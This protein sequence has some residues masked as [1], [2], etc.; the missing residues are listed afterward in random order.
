MP[1]LKPSERNSWS[2]KPSHMQSV[3]L[4]CAIVVPNGLSVFARSAS[5]WIHWWS[6]ETS[7]NLSMSSWVTSRHS[8]GPMVCPTS[9]LSSSIPFTVVGVL[10][11]RSISTA[12]VPG[13]GGQRVSQRALP[14]I[15]ERP[16]V[17]HQRAVEGQLQQRLERR[18]EALS[19]EALRLGVDLVARPHPQR[20]VDLHHG[21][22]EDEGVM[23][24]NVK[25]HLVTLRL[26]DRVR[27]GAA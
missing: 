14:A 24:R 18:V 19:V 25:R 7:A 1:I 20:A 16:A 15:H 23:A 27:R 6:P 21:V 12:V 11:A 26:A 13:V 3:R 2:R 10:M 8:L 17:R 22:P 4:P 9:S 5:T